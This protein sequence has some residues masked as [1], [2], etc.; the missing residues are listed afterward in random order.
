[1]EEPTSPTSAPKP[2]LEEVSR[3]LHAAMRERGRSRKT[4]GEGE[5]DGEWVEFEREDEGGGGKKDI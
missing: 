2:D 1:M 3:N 4:N 5:D